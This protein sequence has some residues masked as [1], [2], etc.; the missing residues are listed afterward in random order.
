MTHE[1]ASL[2][3][4][5]KTDF[6]ALGFE[7]RTQCEA[8]VRTVLDRPDVNLWHIFAALAEALNS[9]H[10]PPPSPQIA[11]LIINYVREVAEIWSRA[12]LKASRAANVENSA[13]RSKFHRFCELVLTAAVEPQA[14][15]HDA[16]LPALMRARRRQQTALPV[17][18]RAV[19][20]ARSDRSDVE[21]LV[22]ADHVEKALKCRQKPT[23]HT[24]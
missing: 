5:M 2:Y 24:A 17:E 8:A 1:G 3:M 13:Y 18:Y 19:V 16:N 4:T 23:S 21:W 22:T 10:S 11:P 6:S 15:R 7:N 9:R 14:R 12:G 20:S